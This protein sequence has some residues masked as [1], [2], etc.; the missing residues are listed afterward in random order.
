MEI[1]EIFYSVQGEGV[2]IGR[3]M[4]F[5]RTTG[6]NIFC[7]FCDS[8]YSWEK[9]KKMSIESIMKE[10]KKFKC[11]NV[12]VTGGEALLQKDIYKLIE[13][14]GEKDYAVF[15]ETNGSIK[16]KETDTIINVVCSPKIVNGK[17]KVKIREDMVD[18]W[19]FVIKTEDDVKKAIE[20]YEDVADKEQIWLMPQ[21]TSREEYLEIAPKVWEW[22][23][24]YGVMFSP[25]EHIVLFG[26]KR[27]V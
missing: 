17:F 21:A 26:Q 9:G 18:C 27:M 20:V 11:K 13:T 24:K 3:P 15:L 2:F 12:C 19:K 5:I 7:S 16:L 1:C 23:K 4:I 25:R 10:I 6:C 22:A 14:L 8:R